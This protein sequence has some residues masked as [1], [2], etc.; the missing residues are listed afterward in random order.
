MPGQ[1][2]ARGRYLDGNN[3]RTEVTASG[4]TDAA[5]R[6]ALQAKVNA[7]REAYKGGD[8]VLNSS[9]KLPKAAAIWLDDKRREGLEKGTVKSYE[10][11]VKNT[12]DGGVLSALTVVE[13]NNIARIEA[14]LKEIADARGSSAAKQ[15][16]KV[17]G[18][19]LAHAE[20]VGAI[21]AS[22]MPRVKTHKASPGS[23][24]DRKCQDR[25]CDGDC[26]K[27]HLDT[28]RA[29]TPEEAAR[30]LDE[31][32]KAR[33]DIGDLC[34][35]MLSTGVRL[36]EALHHTAWSDVDLKAGTVRV[37]GTKTD[38]ADRTLSLSDE[39]VERLTKRAEKYG[40][41]GLV[42]GITYYATKLGRQ[43]DVNNVAKAMRRVFASVGMPWAGSHTFRRTV[44]SWMDEAGSPLAEIANQ[45]GHQ[46]TNVTAGYLGRR[47]AP[48]RAASVM[49]LPTGE[50]P[51][52]RVV[53]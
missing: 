51:N 16:R 18:G 4:R 49:V 25:E 40:R 39:L 53:S 15:A 23:K 42:F 37:R 29:F 41:I 43:R 6:R 38:A 44:A 8:R 50:R 28:D 17:L 52:L 10:F 11:Y 33:A 31:A 3:K 13:A 5:A 48:T 32:D 30:V 7:A 2:Q 34:Y 27:R 12:I 26:G 45:L 46:D 36:S 47:V 19:V 21:P 24:G 22:V 35:F 1:R 9:T 14:W 20:R